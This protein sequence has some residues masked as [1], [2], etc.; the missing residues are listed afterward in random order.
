MDR[1]TV[2][3]KNVLVIGDN[4]SSDSKLRSRYFDYDIVMASRAQLE[5]FWPAMRAG[6]VDQDDKVI[7]FVLG[8]LPEGC[9]GGNTMPTKL[10]WIRNCKEF[11]EQTDFN[12]YT[13][14]EYGA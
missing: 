12:T 2:G 6:M 13:R 5:K 9:L 1:Y 4:D 14:E 11:P 7:H 10:Q 8:Q 3:N